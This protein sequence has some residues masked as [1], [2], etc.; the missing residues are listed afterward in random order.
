MV[1]YEVWLVNRSG[2]LVYNRAFERERGDTAVVSADQL[3]N[4]ASWTYS[5][6]GFAREL[7]SSSGGLEMVEGTDITM[8]IH[9]TATSLMWVIVTDP[10][11]TG[12]QVTP[13]FNEIYS[14][15]SDHVMKNPLY[16]MDSTGTGQ[17]VH[18]KS[19]NEAVDALVHR[20]NGV[21][22]I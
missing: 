2:L 13:L 21:R 5:M 12:Q 20:E 7:S 8:H 17:V 22:R 6:N 19:F 3:V 4:L 10:A 15:Y 16:Q 9:R 18:L 1:V 14:M 11:T